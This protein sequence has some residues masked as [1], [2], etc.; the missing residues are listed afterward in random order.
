MNGNQFGNNWSNSGGNQGM[1]GGGFGAAT[2]VLNPAT[3]GYVTIQDSTMQNCRNQGMAYYSV[4][5][6]GCTNEAFTN[7]QQNT[8][9]PMNNNNNNN[10]GWDNGNN[11]NNNNNGWDNTNNGGGFG[12]GNA[13]TREDEPECIDASETCI[14]NVCRGT[15][16]MAG[17]TN[18]APG[19][20]A[21]GVMAQCTNG[22]K[23]VS[24]TDPSDYTC[25]MNYRP[26]CENPG[27]SRTT[28]IVIGVA[29]AAFVLIV[30]VAVTIRARNVGRQAG[31]GNM[32]SLMSN[33]DSSDSSIF[34]SNSIQR[35]PARY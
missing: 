31:L 6:N 19:L 15:P 20:I 24:F 9:V 11:N 13:G 29:A 2:T 10:D 28:W 5:M 1:N 3:G 25:P 30:V 18:L 8:A 34:L 33:M 22:N 7:G 4:Q 32:R 12:G 14:I 27:F 16:G 17:N 21:P 26:C 35:N 23:C